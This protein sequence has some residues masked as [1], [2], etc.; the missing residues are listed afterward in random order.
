MEDTGLKLRGPLVAMAGLWAACAVA[1]A[2]P[3][4]LVLRLRAHV[5]FLAGDALRGRASA[6]GDER[7]AAEYAA[8]MLRAH[9]LEGAA[10]NGG[11]VERVDLVRQPFAS[12]PYLEAGGRRFEHGAALA[13]YRLSG[14]PVEGPLVRLRPGAAAEEVAGK[15]VLAQLEPGA[16]RAALGVLFDLMEGG[17]RAV[18]VAD[19]PAVASFRTA[20]AGRAPEA[21]TE[22]ATAPVRARG[23]VLLGPEASAVFASLPEGTPV[24]L[25]AKLGATVHET[26]WNA[27]AHLPGTGS[28]GE[29][30][31]LSS[32][33]DH[34]GVKADEAGGDTIF[35]GADDD[36]SGV[37]AVLEMARLLA[38]GGPTRR[39]LLVALFGSEEK[40][41]HGSRAFRERPPVRLARIAANLQFEMLGRPDPLV[42]PRHLWL[43]GFERS[44]LGPW[45]AGRGARLVADPR[46]AENFFRRSDNYALA[47]RGVV[48]HTVSSFG[49]HA[50][51]HRPSDEPRLLDY[52]HMA[53]AVASLVGPVRALLD[54]SERPAWVEGGQPGQ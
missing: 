44:T 13:F 18:L 9:G 34:L 41:G 2:G 46:P 12:A 21:A 20:L 49:L 39:T 5:E 23:L 38:E 51:Y 24:R 19:A 50:D 47:T 37:A 11:Y 7:I 42:P 22:L 43:S 54:A 35:N 8:A 3:E 1:A 26:T 30:V 4:D 33:L 31:L 48:A 14:V 15:V 53:D 17:A 6:S 10:E 40:G 28:D 32:H 36:A 29:A 27:L 52:A 25:D 45:L 16:G